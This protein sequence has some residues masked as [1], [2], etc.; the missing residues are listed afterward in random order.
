MGSRKAENTVEAQLAQKLLEQEMNE[1]R[2]MDKQLSPERLQLLALPKERPRLKGTT[3]YK[4]RKRPKTAKA[5][6]QRQT[7]LHTEPAGSLT[8]G[9]VQ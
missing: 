1:R 2:Q 4:L 5:K 8:S 3:D 9:S 6:N 7:R